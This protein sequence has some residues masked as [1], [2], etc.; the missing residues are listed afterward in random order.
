M[1]L[2][3]FSVSHRDLNWLSL[4]TK[5]HKGGLRNLPLGKAKMMWLSWSWVKIECAGNL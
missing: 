3:K 2:R 5:L 4:S 1:L